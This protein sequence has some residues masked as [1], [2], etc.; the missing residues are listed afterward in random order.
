MDETVNRGNG[1]TTQV[2]FA[3]G[4]IGSVCNDKTSNQMGI[5]EKGI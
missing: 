3:E 5:M 2:H 1:E 4:I